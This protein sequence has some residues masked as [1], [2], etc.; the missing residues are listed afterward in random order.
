MLEFDEEPGGLDQR[1]EIVPSCEAGDSVV[2]EDLAEQRIVACPIDIGPLMRG[3][4]RHDG[5]PGEGHDEGEESRETRLQGCAGGVV[6]VPR[7]DRHTP[8]PAGRA[9]PASRAFAILRFLSFEEGERPLSDIARGVEGTTSTTHRYLTT[10]KKIGLIDRLD[11]SRK[12]LLATAPEKK[13]RRSPQVGKFARVALCDGQVE[14]V[15]RA[16]VQE[17]RE[18]RHGLRGFLVGRTGRLEQLGPLRDTDLPDDPGISR[19]LL[20]GLLIVRFL[21]LARSVRPLYAIAPGVGLS[22]ATTHRYLATLK[23][24]RLVEQIEATHK[25]RLATDANP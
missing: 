7:G 3:N 12:Y 20:R 18:G 14:K 19:S 4:E 21:F 10:L 22:P 23:H 2:V 11:V 25:Y 16:V 13:S 8:G 17:K 5:H 24:V 15:L 1:G 9:R 6:P